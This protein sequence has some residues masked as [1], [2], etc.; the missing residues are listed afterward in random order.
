M[1]AVM[2]AVVRGGRA[3]SGG[4]GARVVDDVG[5][6]CDGAQRSFG[7]CAVMITHARAP[8]RFGTVGPVCQLQTR[9][10]AV[11]ACSAHGFGSVAPPD[12]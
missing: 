6:G 8:S 4:A 11:N 10:L 1:A 7:C 5:G 12:L 2:A 9:S 3:F